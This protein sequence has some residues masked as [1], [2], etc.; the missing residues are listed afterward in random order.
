MDEATDETGRFFRPGPER[1]NLLLGRHQAMSNTLNYLYSNS[2]CCGPVMAGNAGKKFA[3]LFSLEDLEQFLLKVH[4]GAFKKGKTDKK[5]VEV[6]TQVFTEGIVGAYN[7]AAGSFDFDSP[8]HKM[9]EALKKN[10]F[11]FSAAKNRAEIVSLSSALR[12]AN[13]KLRSYTDFKVEASKIVDE[14]QGSWLQ[15][16]YD[17]AVNSSTLAARWVEYDDD[18]LLRY[19][20]VKDDRVREAHRRLDGITKPKS[21]KFWDTYYPPLGWKCRCTI[22]P[23][24]SARITP[25]D[26]I[27]ADAIDSVPAL[28]RENMAKKGIAFPSNHPYYKHAA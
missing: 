15:T 2:Y 10:A 28:F 9:L 24:L 11:H 16:E 26:E 21:D 12:D 5:R 13:G 4:K 3:D 25:D 19:E 27:P 6:Y 17:T 20:T 7:T 1:L 22:T 23:V 14:Y 18:E 8:D